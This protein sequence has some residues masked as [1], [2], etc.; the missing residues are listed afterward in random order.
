MRDHPKHKAP[1]MGGTW[2]VKLKNEET[3]SMLKS[4]F[5]VMLGYEK[6]YHTRLDKG[7]DQHV[8]RKLLW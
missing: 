8:F 4:T 7:I 5:D 2:G 1:I 3:R 6:S